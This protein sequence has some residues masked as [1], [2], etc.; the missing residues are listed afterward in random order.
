MK[1]RITVDVVDDR[2]R[3]I[4]R[5]KVVSVNRRVAKLY[6]AL[7]GSNV[8]E[9]VAQDVLSHALRALEVSIRAQQSVPAPGPS[10]AP[11][12]R[13]KGVADALG[14]NLIN[15]AVAN[16]GPNRNVGPGPIGFGRSGDSR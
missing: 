13:S 3:S 16:E 9:M 10:G 14:L 8:G 15:E 4:R 7:D 5:Q 6:E 1:A 11:V 12:G 2:G